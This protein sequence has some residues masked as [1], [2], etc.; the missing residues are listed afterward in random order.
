MSQRDIDTLDGSLR[1]RIE[2]ALEAF[3]VPGAVVA[4][5]RGNDDFLA[6]FGRRRSDRP[7]LVGPDTAFDV[8][9]CAKSYVSTAIGILASDGKLALDDP[10]RRYVPELDLDDHW[11]SEHVTIRDF[12]SNRV[13]LSRQTPIEAF[14]NEELGLD[15]IFR[16][17]RFIKRAK[18]FRGGYIYFNLGFM[19]C[20]RIVARVSGMSYEQFL[21]QRLFSPLGM[22]RSASGRIPFGSFSNR[23]AGHTTNNGRIVPL[24][25]MVFEN[26]QGAGG[27]YSSGKDALAWL[28]LHMRENTRSVIDPAILRELHQ[29][30]TIMRVEETG[31]MH[32]LPEASLCAYCLGWWTSEFHDQ[33]LVQHAG[34]MFGWQAQTSVLPSLDIGVAVYINIHRPIHHAIAYM[35]MEA[36]LGT[37]E[38]DWVRIAKERLA[39]NTRAFVRSVE[40]A[41][42]SDMSEVLSLPLESYTGF[43]HHPAAGRIEIEVV[44]GSRSLYMKQLDGRFWDMAL[45]PLGGNVVEAEFAN[46]AA[47]DYLLAPGRARFIVEGERVTG[48]DGAS[49][50]YRRED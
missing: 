6:V 35:V 24:E 44:P 4:V 5:A 1:Q 41:L 28:R 45:K 42:P 40:E 3:E 21:A 30:H 14:P 26:V 49:T 18:P 32:R 33:R 31:L 29:P 38:R 47:N 22:T 43:Y 7:E 8:G 9:S 25:D 17:M 12:L 15:E 10:A 34:G 27:I 48:F 50:L 36:L 39:H 20:A 2:A 37:P 13:G 23:A 11:I 16:R 46:Q 19:I